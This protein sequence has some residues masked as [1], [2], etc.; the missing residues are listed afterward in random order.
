MQG[1]TN[2]IS[3]CGFAFQQLHLSF[4]RKSKHDYAKIQEKN[5][6]ET[7]WKQNLAYTV[8]KIKQTW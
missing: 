8:R 4:K 2:H 6:G 3:L 1:V 7:D 5:V